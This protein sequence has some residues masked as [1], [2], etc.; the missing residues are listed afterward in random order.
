MKWKFNLL[1]FFFYLIFQIKLTNSFLCGIKTKRSSFQRQLNVWFVWSKALNA[2]I[3]KGHTCENS[4]KVTSLY[5]HCHACFA[6]RRSRF[7]RKTTRKFAFLFSYNGALRTHCWSFEPMLS[8]CFYKRVPLALCRIP[9]DVY[10]CV[11]T[12]HTMPLISIRQQRCC[13]KGDRKRLEA[14]KHA[15]FKTSSANVLWGRKCI[16][17]IWWASTTHTACLETNAGNKQEPCVRKP[18]EAAVTNYF[19]YWL[20][21]GLFYILWF[22]AWGLTRVWIM[23]YLFPTIRTS[24]GPTFLK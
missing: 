22:N 11:C 13:I 9:T 5:L 24:R 17:G 6:L 20:I 14:G 2:R 3:K 10:V 7:L 1:F 15:Q 16:Q 18:V 4:L 23:H 21:C 19:Y 12:L 8:L